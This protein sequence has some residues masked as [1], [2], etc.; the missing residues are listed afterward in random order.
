MAALLLV[1]VSLDSFLNDYDILIMSPEKKNPFICLISLI[2]LLSI[3]GNTATFIVNI[4]RK[5]RGFYRTCLLSLAFSDLVTTVTSAIPFIA[6]LSA[7]S[8]EIWILGEILCDGI[9]FAYTASLLINS[10]TLAS[11][12]LVRY[13]AI[14]K[15]FKNIFWNPGTFTC[16]AFIIVNYGLA[17]ILSSPIITT[18]HIKNSIL[19]ITNPNNR[20]EIWEERKVQICTPII[21]K[22]EPSFIFYFL[23]YGIV[24]LPI[25]LVFLLLNC[26]IIKEMWKKQIC[27]RKCASLSIKILRAANSRNELSIN[28]PLTSTQQIYESNQVFTRHN[29][30]NNRLT[31]QT[32]LCFIIIVLML[33]FLICRFPRSIFLMLYLERVNITFD[34]WAL[35]FSLEVLSLI[36]CVLNPLLYTFMPET[37]KLLNHMT[38]YFKLIEHDSAVLNGTNKHFLKGEKE[39]YTILEEY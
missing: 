29:I 30:Q 6:Q 35:N 12:T 39:L 34:D 20:N 36:S 15:V 23:I 24:V 22:E 7:I 21:N 19:I 25:I 5:M 26:I 11:I 1:N 18:F 37:L 10:I 16:I 4:K 2:T 3:L 13:M 33:V 32:K 8:T 28:R 38:N 14:K 31:Y 9:P 27:F 17:I